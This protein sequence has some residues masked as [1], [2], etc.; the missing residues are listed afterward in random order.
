MAKKI[1]AEKNPFAIPVGRP[2][3]YKPIFCQLLIDHM[4]EGYSFES[5]AG[6]DDVDVDRDTLYEWKNTHPEFSDAFTRGKSKMLLKDEETLK[7]GID[8]SIKVNHQ[9]LTLKMY[10]C[11]KWTSRSEV[12]EKPVKNMSKDELLAEAEALIEKEKSKVKE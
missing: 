10:N 11:H 8:G 1:N 4:R 6:R 2:S 5:F 9:L 12:T 3:K 7:K